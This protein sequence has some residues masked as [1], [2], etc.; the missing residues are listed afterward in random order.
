MKSIYK[1]PN[2]K[3]LK[4]FLELNENKISKLILTGDFFAHPE[5]GIH[6]IEDE[7]LGN[8]LSEN[9]NELIDKINESVQKNNIELFGLSPEA[10]A[11][12]IYLA[13]NGG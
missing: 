8:E 4:V 10:I 13:K 3:L 7:L 11:E 1:V 5:E 9:R 6:A 2:G 12:A